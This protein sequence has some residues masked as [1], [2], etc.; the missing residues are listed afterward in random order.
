MRKII[1]A[2]K[3]TRDKPRVSV[4]FVCMGNICRSPLAE[5]VLRRRLDDRGLAGSVRV[6]SAGTHGYHRGVPPDERA[7]AAALRRG[8]DISALRARLVEAD[9]FARFDLILAMDEDNEARLLEMADQACRDRVRLLLEFAPGG[10]R[11]SVPDPYYGSPLG[12]ERVLD[13]VEEAMDGLL[14]EI[15][16]RVAAGDPPG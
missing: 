13:L 1:S 9:D 10:A 11:R 12:F 7:Q 8:V 4:L 14:A 15:E 5:G 6:D 16:A 3:A 2:W